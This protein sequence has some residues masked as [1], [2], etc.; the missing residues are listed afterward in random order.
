MP[1]RRLAAVVILAACF[2]GVL[3]TLTHS[4]IVPTRGL[5]A[6]LCDSGGSRP[7]P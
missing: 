3:S 4:E 6:G 7:C 1:V 5:T 2:G